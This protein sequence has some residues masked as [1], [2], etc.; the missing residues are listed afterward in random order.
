MRERGEER[1][2]E[3]RWKQRW[4]QRWTSLPSSIYVAGWS[5]DLPTQSLTVPPP[6]LPPEVEAE[7][8]AEAEV[9]GEGECKDEN[10]SHPILLLLLG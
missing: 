1:R 6:A 8:K 10:Y 5:R 7:A 3:V 4:R 9:K 2:R